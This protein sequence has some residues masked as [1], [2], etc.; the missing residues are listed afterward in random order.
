MLAV[1]IV[2]ILVVSE[3]VMQSIFHVY[4]MLLIALIIALAH[5]TKK[6]E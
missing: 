3:V 4:G 6:L 2:T 5:H 1:S